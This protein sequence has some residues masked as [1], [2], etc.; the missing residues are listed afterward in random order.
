MG[1]L[2]AAC[3]GAGQRIR[4]GPGTPGYMGTRMARMAWHAYLFILSTFFLLL[5]FF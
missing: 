5:S 3:C 2:V 4:Q 1:I